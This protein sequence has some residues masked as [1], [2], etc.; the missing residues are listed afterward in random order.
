MKKSFGLERLTDCAECIADRRLLVCLTILF[1]MAASFRLTV[2]IYV[3]IFQ[4]CKSSAFSHCPYLMLDTVTIVALARDVTV[5][6]VDKIP[7][8]Q[9]AFADW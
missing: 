9:L 5:C 8:W 2:S 6:A 7:P 3:D 1:M 4:H